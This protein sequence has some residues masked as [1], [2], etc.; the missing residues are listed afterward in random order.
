MLSRAKQLPEDSPASSGDGQDPDDVVDGII[1]IIDED[2]HI[3]GAGS[4][5][6]VAG[7][8]GLSDA[9]I[10]GTPIGGHDGL[11]NGDDAGT[12]MSGIDDDVGGLWSSTGGRRRRDAGR[13]F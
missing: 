5:S 11:V 3:D 4:P 7:A 1:S 9:G 6:A 8:D 2:D 13:F 12:G 10:M